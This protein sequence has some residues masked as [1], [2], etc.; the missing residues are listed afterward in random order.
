MNEHDPYWARQSV[1][2]GLT[3]LRFLRSL[4]V[5]LPG[6]VYDL[7]MNGLHLNQ[8]IHLE[9]I[10]VSGT[11]SD[12]DSI[13]VSGVA[14]AIEKSQSLAHLEVHYPRDYPPPVEGFLAKRSSEIH[15]R[16]SHVS[17]ADMSYKFRV[18]PHLHALRSLELTNTAP[19]RRP[20]ESLMESRALMAKIYKSLTDERILLTRIVIDDVFPT[21][22][23]YLSSYSGILTEIRIICL[24]K[25]IPWGE[26]DELAALFYTFILP[27]HIDSFEILD[28]SPMFTCEWCFHPK[29]YSLFSKAKCLRSLS[30]SFAFADSSVANPNLPVDYAATPWMMLYVIPH[31]VCIS[32]SLKENPS[33]RYL[34]L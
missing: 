8:L 21:F 20:L 15:L 13:I 9:K 27:N 3:S 2:D 17:I 4:K 33:S 11:C 19:Y 1:S 32:D 30:I 5:I 29:E 14:G 26:L 10:F 24:Y 31:L 6:S 12:Y 22:L 28:I 23:D 7:T 16:F 25:P 18:K 34:P